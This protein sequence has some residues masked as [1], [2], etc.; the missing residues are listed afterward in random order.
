METTEIVIAMM[1]LVWIWVLLVIRSSTANWMVYHQLTMC[2]SLGGGLVV[3]LV[4]VWALNSCSCLLAV[5]AYSS[6]V[7]VSVLK[8]VDG[9]HPPGPSSNQMW[10]DMLE[11]M[12]TKS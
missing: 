12:C 10:R 5:V 1:M 8:S 4:R 2:T 3:G 9:V 11:Q 6:V 7:V